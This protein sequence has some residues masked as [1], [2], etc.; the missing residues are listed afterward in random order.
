M[1]YDLDAVSRGETVRSIRNHHSSYR[2]DVS[3]NMRTLG[4]AALDRAKRVALYAYR[5]KRHLDIFTG[6]EVPHRKANKP[7]AS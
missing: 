2:G 7:L 1:N 4:Q 6:K 5:A 3:E